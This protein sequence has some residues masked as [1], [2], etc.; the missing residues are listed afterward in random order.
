MILY[1]PFRACLLLLLAAAAVDIPTELLTRVEAIRQVEKKFGGTLWPGWDPTSTPLAVH[2]ANEFSLVVGHPQPPAGYRPYPTPIVSAPVF[3]SDST[4]GIPL[5]NTARSFGGRVTSFIGFQDVMDKPG[6]EEAVALGMHELFHAH[7]QRIAPNKYGNILAVLWGDYPEFSASNR[8][9]LQLESEALRS[10]ILAT[11][12]DDVQRHAAEFLGIRAER[13]K[14]LTPQA[15]RYESGEE[16]VE[17]LCRYIEVR[18]LELAYPARA[19]LRQQR[20]DELAKVGSLTRDRERFYVLGM[21]VGL[22]LDR[23][24]PSWKQ[25]YETTEAMPG[26]LLARAVPAAKFDRNLRTQIFDQQSELNKRQEEGSRRIGILMSKGKRVVLEVAGAKENVQLRGINPN[27]S[28]QL[29]PQ[30]VAQTFL[31]L[32]LKGGVGDNSFTWRMEFTSV[33][34]IYDKQQDAFW[35]MLPEEAVTEALERL[36]EKPERFTVKGPGFL[37]DL[38]HVT[39]S[40]RTNEVRISLSEDLK[41]KPLLKPEILKP[42][43]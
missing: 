32:D 13:R 3:M 26:E 12:P 37:L 22:L 19:D 38:D 36:A 6:V 4:A 9:L 43:L 23:V 30:H 27:G 16:A 40:N 7:E 21:G 8:V 31:M 28:V 39:V 42:P 41:R 14:A 10:A 20:I 33:P 18:T 11:S 35:C 15:V 5:A 1:S 29:T 34:V 17:G 24:R 25:E 2:K